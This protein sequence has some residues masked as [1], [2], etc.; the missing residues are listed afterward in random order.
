MKKKEKKKK[1]ERKSK[2]G[3]FSPVGY[4]AGNDSGTLFVKLNVVQGN[5]A[6]CFNSLLMTQIPSFFH[7]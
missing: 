1:K 5:S 7:L 2:E 6:H 4:K 3:H